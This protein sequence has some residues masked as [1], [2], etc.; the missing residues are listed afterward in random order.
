MLELI[1]RYCIL[2][3]D[4]PEGATYINTD[5]VEFVRCPKCS[6]IWRLKPEIDFE[7]YD[8]PN[9]HTGCYDKRRLHRINKGRRQLAL[10]D[11]YRPTA[12]KGVLL[13]VGCSMGYFLE[14][15]VN[16]GWR[17]IGIEVS[18]HAVKQCRDNGLEAYQSDAA[19]I[20]ELGLLFDVV[21]MKHVLEHFP[22]PVD[23]LQQY[24][25]LLKPGGLLFIEI[26]NAG[27]YKGCLLKEKYKFYRLE[28]AGAQ[29]FYYFTPDNLRRLLKMAGFNVLLPCDRW[30]SVLG[31]FGLS[32]QFMCVAQKPA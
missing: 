2:C 10:I 18:S 19:G 20:K 12:E 4:K 14:A 3:D 13:E 8:D 1:P 25:S 5:D 29:H 31:V 7:A 26:P 9:Y 15:A 17:A 23:C 6:L 30:N 28:N 22:D 11:K 21:V 32:K 27:Y 24:Y 16:D